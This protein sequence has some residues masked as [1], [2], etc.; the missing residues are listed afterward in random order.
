MLDA[1]IHTAQLTRYGMVELSCSL[2]MSMQE[3]MYER[4][5]VR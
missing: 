1:F 5:K 3:E 2:L 4:M